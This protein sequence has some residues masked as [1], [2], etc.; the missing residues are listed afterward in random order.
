MILEDKSKEIKMDENSKIQLPKLRVASSS[1]GIT[2]GACVEREQI[3]KIVGYRFD[4]VRENYLRP[5]CRCMESI[6][7]GHYSTCGNGCVY[8]YATPTRST[9]A[10]IR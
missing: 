8:C 5:H 9:S 3:E 4:K 1:L 10:A 6:D 2:R 7:I